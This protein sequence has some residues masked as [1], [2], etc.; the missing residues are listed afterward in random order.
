MEEHYKRITTR[1]K[2]HKWTRTLI[3]QLWEL[4]RTLWEHRNNIEHTEMTPAKQQQLEMM[5]A[6]AR[7]KLQPGC[8][9]VQ[10]QD[11]YLFA[12]PELVLSMTPLDLTLW[13]KDVGLAR[14]SVDDIRERKRQQAARLRA[15]MH[16]WLSSHNP[17]AQTANT[18][19]ATT[20][21]TLTA[22][23]HAEQ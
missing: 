11:R 15:A 18:H 16:A 21:D 12:E 19:G 2:H 5:M 1:K 8:A 13:L 4:Q 9:D 20:A 17:T 3:Q 14:K 10:R 6:K 22:D 23:S 7:D